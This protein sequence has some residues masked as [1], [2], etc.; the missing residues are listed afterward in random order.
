MARK[1]SIRDVA[2]KAQVSV[3][4]VSNFLNDIP[5]SSK[6]SD[7]IRQAIDELGFTGNLLAKGMRMQRS[8][9]VGLCIPYTS[10]ANFTVLVDKLDECVSETG[11][12]LM[13]VLSRQDE[14]QEFQRVKRL[15]AFKIAGLLLVPSLRPQPILDY[16]HHHQLPT[17]I[18]GRP[19]PGETRFDQVAVDHERAMLEVARALIADGHRDILFVVRFPS[20]G[21]TMRRLATLDAAIGDSGRSVRRR[22]FVGP[23]TEEEFTAGLIAEMQGADAPTAVIVSNSQMT[24]WTLAAMRRLPERVARGTALVC[25]QKPEWAETV[26]VPLSYVEQPIRDMAELSWRTLLERIETRDAP[27]KTILLPAKVV[28]NTP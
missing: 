1:P 19:A 27:T 21:V 4:T 7:R 8:S 13:Q 16:L 25:L 2:L 23:G 3:G 15:E 26:A 14:A 22:L 5:V 17:I 28:M 12:E 24:S 20:L 11:Y 18:L 6:R 9:V 10:L